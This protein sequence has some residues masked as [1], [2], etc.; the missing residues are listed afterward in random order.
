MLQK[1]ETDFVQVPVKVGLSE[2]MDTTPLHQ[3]LELSV[4]KQS[5]EN[6]DDS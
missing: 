3:I 6:R 4:Q 5:R 1:R 2:V